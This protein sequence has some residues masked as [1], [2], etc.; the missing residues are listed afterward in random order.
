MLDDA[1]RLCPEPLVTLQAECHPYL[2]QSKVIAACRERGL[3]LTAYC[4][5]ARGRIK[6]DPVLTEIGTT[7]RQDRR[8]GRVCAG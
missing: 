8:A 1:I 5:L 3:V 7:Q 4:P 2:D 6:G